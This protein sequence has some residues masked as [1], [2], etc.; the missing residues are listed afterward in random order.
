MKEAGKK[1]KSIKK[2]LVDFSWLSQL[3]YEKNNTKHL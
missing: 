3:L 1:E 2:R